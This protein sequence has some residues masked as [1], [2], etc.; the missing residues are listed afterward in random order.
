MKTTTQ[1]TFTFGNRLQRSRELA[2]IGVQQMA[3]LF[4]VSRSAIA[5]WEAGRNL[6]SPVKIQR[7]ADLVAERTGN[8]VAEVLKFLD[9]PTPVVTH[10]R[11]GAERRHPRKQSKSK[12][13]WP[14][15]YEEQKVP[16]AFPN[17]A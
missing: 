12:S 15:S 14:L 16:L 3:D 11:R 13:T 1:L 4:F 8:T 7:W 17:A 5:N 9:P 2:D 6:P 10:E